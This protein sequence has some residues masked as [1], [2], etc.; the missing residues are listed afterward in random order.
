MCDP[1]QAFREA[2]L[3][4]LNH[5]PEVIEPD[6]FVR[7]AT[8]ERRGDD[9]GWCKLF[10]DLR[11]GVFGCN[12]ASI[13]ET[14]QAE[15]DRPMTR[16]Q[17]AE[18]ARQVAEATAERVRV[19]R[20]Q[21]AENATRIARLRAQCVPLVPGDPAT[22]Y[23]KRRGFGGVWP[24]PA[25][26]RLHRALPYWDGD[27]K[28]GDFP[29]MVAP[30]V[31]PSGQIVALHRTY[32]TADGRKAD[33]PTVKKL[34]ATAGLLAGACIPLHEPSR[35]VIGISEGIETALAAWLASSVPTV[36]AYSAGNLAAYRWPAGVQRLVIFADSDRAGR[37]AADALRARAFAAWLH[38][39]VMTPSD[40]GADWA[41]VWEQ[42]GAV[43]VKGVAA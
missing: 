24:L 28:I 38:C 6:K 13:G 39:S 15:R 40:D 19:Q 14:W 22:L 32:L 41:D 4:V 31:S 18:L 9:A 36:A 35:G 2:I 10:A 23:L 8:S 17:R 20:E 33:V 12:R 25:C 16:E 3:N 30:L 26:L 5:A 43:A 1:V 7:F 42:R 29:A 11:G 27:Q 34:T 21:W 37:E